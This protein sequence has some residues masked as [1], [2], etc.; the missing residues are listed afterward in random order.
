MGCRRCFELLSVILL[1]N[2]SGGLIISAHSQ[3]HVKDVIIH[4]E[5]GRTIKMHMA[6]PVLGDFTVNP[7]FVNNKIIAEPFFHECNTGLE[8]LALDAG[9]VIFVSFRS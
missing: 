9:K 4:K 7:V 3:Y 6:G 1:V 5:L 2:E 8:V